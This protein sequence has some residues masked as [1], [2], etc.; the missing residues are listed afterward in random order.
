[1]HLER[2]HTKLLALIHPHHTDI[3]FVRYDSS[4]W[5]FPSPKLLYGFLGTIFSREST[6]F[7]LQHI[8]HN[9]MSSRRRSWGSTFNLQTMKTLI[10]FAA[11]AEPEDGLSFNRVLKKCHFYSGNIRGYRFTVYIK[12]YFHALDIL[13]QRYQGEINAIQTSCYKI[14]TSKVTPNN[15]IYW[16][17]T[18]HSSSSL[19]WSAIHLTKYLQYMRTKYMMILLRAAQH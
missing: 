6:F 13:Q 1:M 4:F 3:L 19:S 10:S 2:D 16:I 12:R 11:F 5:V 7:F 15:L 18:D 17:L 9:C 8:T 14:P